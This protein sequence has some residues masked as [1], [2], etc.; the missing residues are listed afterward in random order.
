MTSKIELLV[1]NEVSSEQLAVIGEVCSVTLAL[2]PDVRAKVI[3]DEGSAF[4]AVLTIGLLGLTREEMLSMPGLKLICCYGVGYKGVDVEAAKELGITVANGRGANVNCAADH[5]MGLVISTIRNFRR[6]DQLCREGVWRTSIPQPPNVSGK[7]MGIF[8]FGMVG[9]KIAKRA[10]A[11]D[12]EIGYHNRRPKAEC[13]HHYFDDLVSLAAWC[14]V[15][16]CAAPGGAETKHSINADV[17]SALG[18]E[19]FLV[20]VGR[21]S[22]VDTDLLAG[23]L[24]DSTIAGAGIDVYESEPSRPEALLGLDNLLITPHLAGWSLEAT[25]AQLEVFMANV[26]GHFAGS[27]A[28]A[29]V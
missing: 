1:L 13:P 14:D 27:G 25:A 28:V 6:L 21:G 8:G 10:E 11:F 20:N 3:Q 12:M 7:R 5:A 9:E 4:Q 24:R 17:L 2:T 23:A 15:L 22:L 16:V 29:P 19:G 26:T 18:P